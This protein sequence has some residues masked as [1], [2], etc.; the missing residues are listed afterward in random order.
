VKTQGLEHIESALAAGR[1]AILC[2]A[3]FGSY[4]SCF[5]VLGALGFPITLITNWSYGDALLSPI[6]RLFSRLIRNLPVTN[7]FRRPNIVRREGKIGVAVEATIV[8]RKDELIA[9]MLDHSDYGDPDAPK[10]RA[11][12]VP[13]K[14]L[15]RPAFMLPWIIT[16]AQLID[17]PVLMA[18]MHRSGD[19]RH[20]VLEISPP[21]SVEGDVVTAFQRCL[22]AVEVAIRRNPAHWEK[23]NSNALVQLGMLSAE[24]RF[25]RSV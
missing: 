18:F 10:D 16:I 14:F 7:H 5:S 4:R 12:P 20:Q 2:S 23:W 24:E 3:H 1:G 19:W 9:T 8:L 21:I 15:N 17:A 11:Q 22:T 25:R 6:D 13:M